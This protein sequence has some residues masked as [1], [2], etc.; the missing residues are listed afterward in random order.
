MN[1]SMGELTAVAVIVGAV[2]VPA[3][4]SIYRLVTGRET[5]KCCE[6]SS[7]AGQDNRCCRTVVEW[8]V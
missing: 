3:A 4:R 5:G 2:V 6:C 8:V 1:G 7:C